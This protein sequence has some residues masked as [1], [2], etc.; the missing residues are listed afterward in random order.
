MATNKINLKEV[1][2]FIKN[3]SEST[4]IYIGCDSEKR[5]KNGIYQADYVTV[6]IVHKDGCKGAKIFYDTSTETDYDKNK[7]RPAMRLMNEVIKAAQMYLDLGDAFG[8]RKVEIHLDINPDKRHGS[9]CAV[10]SAVGYIKGMCGMTPLIK[11][12]AFAASHCSDHIVRGKLNK[13]A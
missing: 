8:T 4:K 7:S 1:K 10:D 2:E 3:S 9:S 5:R 12:D 13:A 11:P 6:V